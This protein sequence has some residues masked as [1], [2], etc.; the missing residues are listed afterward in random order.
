M[1]TSSSAEE[2]HVS[3]IVV[4]RT[5]RGFLMKRDAVWSYQIAIAPEEEEYYRAQRILALCR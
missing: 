2:F 1:T 3:L 4:V 5:F